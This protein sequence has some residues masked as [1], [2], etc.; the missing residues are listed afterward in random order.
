MSYLL[1]NK[2]TLKWVISNN[3]ID[4]TPL[5][6]N[7]HWKHW[8]KIKDI[9]LLMMCWSLGNYFANTKN[10][11]DKK[12]IIRWLLSPTTSCNSK[13][14]NT[15]FSKLIHYIFQTTLIKISKKKFFTITC[16]YIYSFILKMCLEWH[17]YSHVKTRSTSSGSSNQLKSSNIDR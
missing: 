16:C 13:I 10:M 8:K 1:F 4:A 11:M 15:V 9:Y 7:S 5:F 2:D 17:L 14:K 6:S 12:G 3:H